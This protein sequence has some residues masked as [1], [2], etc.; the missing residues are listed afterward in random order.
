[1]KVYPDLSVYGL[2]HRH[3]VDMQQSGLTENSINFKLGLKKK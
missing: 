2:R 3:S 1:M